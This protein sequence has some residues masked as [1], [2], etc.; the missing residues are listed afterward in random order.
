M[1]FN[2]ISLIKDLRYDRFSLCPECET[3]SF[4][5]EWLTPKELQKN[6]FKNCPSCDNLIEYV[7]LVKPS[8]GQN[9]SLDF[10][11]L[12]QRLENIAQNEIRKSATNI[13]ITSLS[14]QD[15]SKSKIKIDK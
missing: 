1:F 11:K 2:F 6:K 10:K 12:Q 3:F 9:P 15:K 7:F 8:T 13:A 5:G 14:P 4:I